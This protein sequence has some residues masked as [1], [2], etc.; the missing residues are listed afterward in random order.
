MWLSFAVGSALFL[1]MRRVYEKKL[2]A[3]FGNFSI[4]FVTLAFSLPF[5]LALFLFLPIPMSI[6]DLPW[7]FWWPLIV[8]WVVLYPI[9]NYLLYRSLRE[10]ELSEVTP[11]GSLLPVFNAVS[12]FF[13]I[14][15]VPTLFGGVGIIVTVFATYL[16]LTDLPAEASAQVGVRA[17]EKQKYNLPVLF[18]IGSVICTA[19]GSTLDKVAVE[20]STP[21]FYSF[22]NIFGASIVFLILAFATGQHRELKQVRRFL[23]TL[24]MLGVV[25]TLGFTAAMFAFSYGPTSYVL[26]LRSGGFLLAALWGIVFLH[27]SLS[28]KKITALI[29]FVLGTFFLAVG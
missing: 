4:S 27:E 25:L 9:Q 13:I 22:V 17:E 19:I 26:A 5:T 2:T 14:Q 21:V 6:G 10:A 18:M 20:V 29:L 8:I 7:R 11:V 15:E 24:T 1:A 16:L 23:P 3:Y 28:R 12:S